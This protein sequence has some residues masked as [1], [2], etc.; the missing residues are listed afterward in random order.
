MT[1]TY[2]RTRTHAR[3]HTQT[4]THENNPITG[5][6]K[7]LGLQEFEDPR[8]SRQ[9]AHEGGKVVS[10]GTGHL[11]PQKIFLVLISVRS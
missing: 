1:Y 8:I 2:E 5:L 9:Y 10:F 7:P 11:Y 3:T 4:H 6:D